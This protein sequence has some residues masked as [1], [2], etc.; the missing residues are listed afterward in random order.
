MNIAPEA[1]GHRFD[2]GIL[3]EYDIRGVYGETLGAADAW[4]LGRSFATMVRHSLASDGPV[5]AAARPK[6]AVGYD[7]RLSSP[8]LEEAL[9]AG[10]IASGID[11]LRIGLGPSPMLYFAEAS[12]EE[13]IGGIQ[14]TGSHN[15]PDHNGFKIVLRGAPVFGARLAELGR[16]ALRGEWFEGAGRAE[17]REILDAYVARLLA[18]L[19]DVPKAA[20][21][22]LRIGWDAGNGAAG[23]VLDRLV[24]KLPGVH[25]VL[26]STV[27]GHFPN[28]HPDPTVEANLA[29]LRS[30]VAAK[31]LDF[32]VAFDG[33]AD[34]IGVVDSLG[35][36]I[37]GDQLLALFAKD[38]L[39]R[40]PDSTVIG[41]VKMSQTTFDA[42]AGLGGRPVLS[43]SGHSLIKSR[44][45]ETGA[46]LGGE[47]SG[48]LFF[49]DDYFGFD[50]GI[51]AAVRLMAATARLGETVTVMRSAMPETCA[52]P[53]L[54]FAVAPERKFAAIGEVRS[55]LEAAGAQM[56]VLDGV[57]VNTEDGWW[58][59]RASNTQDMLTAR[60]ES[61]T[62]PGLERLVAEIDAQL[63]LSGLSRAN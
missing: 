60:A 39:R 38:V 51:Y 27:D 8:E 18:G 34:R 62:E 21:A 20:M 61:N 6:V 48:H 40:H 30:L 44:M 4:A 56:L 50:D 23:P 17:T 22:R 9:V 37:W 26:Y 10:L 43:A 29:D 35:R 41:D 36:V 32:G 33:D 47:M 24:E 2:P 42:I 49:A 55:R 45:K 3:R 1:A 63:A 57:R 25:H 12:L 19:A 5:S 11:V 7:G 31:N 28:H 13:V 54:R 58:L 16:I 59:L 52:T 46:L 14:V 15:P 53:E